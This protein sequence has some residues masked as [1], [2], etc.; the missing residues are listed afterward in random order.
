MSP[1]AAEIPGDRKRSSVKGWNQMEDGYAF[2]YEDP[3]GRHRH[4]ASDVCCLCHL[5]CCWLAALR[6]QQRC[7]LVILA[8]KR[9]AIMVK[10][11]PMDDHLLLQ[12]MAPKNF[13]EPRLLDLNVNDYIEPPSDSAGDGKVGTTPCA[14]T[15]DC[16]RVVCSVRVAQ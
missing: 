14:S 7:L 2:R 16:I 13:K 9:S 1:A 5:A 3:T 6:L 8:G 4:I 12:W 15:V 11:V 10:M